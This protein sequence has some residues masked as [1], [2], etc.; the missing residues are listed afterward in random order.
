MSKKD[1][2]G[3]GDREKKTKKDDI[4]FPKYYENISDKLN[5]K[6]LRTYK[7]VPGWMNDAEWIFRD[8]FGDK[9]DLPLGGE[10]FVE[11][12]TLLGQSSVRMAELIQ[13]CN[14]S[15]PDKK[16][17]QFDSIDTFY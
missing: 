16:M 11:I 7:N 13:K 14:E 5:N 6:T 10:H 9:Y 4:T 1:T 15:H 3:G 8:L 2:W 12:G 17:I